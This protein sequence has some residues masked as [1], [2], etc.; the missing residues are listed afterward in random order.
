MGGGD[1]NTQ[2]AEK[3]GLERRMGEGTSETRRG[4]AQS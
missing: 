4:E 3:Q 2:K 1:E